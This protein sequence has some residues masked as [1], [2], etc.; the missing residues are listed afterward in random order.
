MTVLE[1]HDSSCLEVEGPGHFGALQD[2]TSGICFPLEG[3]EIFKV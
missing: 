3:L 1:M 2:R